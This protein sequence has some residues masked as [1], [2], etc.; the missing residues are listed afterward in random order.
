M[1]YLAAYNTSSFSGSLDGGPIN[2]AI[3]SSIFSGSTGAIRFGD[4]LQPPSGGMTIISDS[5]TQLG[6]ASASATPLFW[7]VN[8]LIDTASIL[9][10]INA[11]PERVT[12][13]SFTTTSSAY[14]YLV[15]SSKY[16]PILGTQPLNTPV[17]DGLVMY[18][19]AGQLV[20]YPTTASTWYDISGNN[21]S[22]SLINGPTFNIN[23]AIV[24]DGVD[25]S[26]TINNVP[27]SY[28]SSSTI[29]V[30]FKVGNYYGTG[31]FALAGYNFTG[32]NYSQGTT[33]IIYVNQSGT[34]F[35]SLI[36]TSQ[37]Y[38]TVTSVSTVPI[39]RYYTATLYK[40]TINGILKLY[41]NGK[42]ESSNTFN[43]ATYAQWP[44]VGTYIG[45]NNFIIG[46]YASNNWGV[47]P[48]LNGS[49]ASTKLY[50]KLLS[51][52]EILQ[53][54]YQAPIVTDGLVFA[55]DANNLVSYESGSSLTYSLT[56]SY[57]GSLT[58]GTRFTSNNGGTFLFDGIDDYINVSTPQSLNPGTGSFSLDFWCNISTN[59]P[60]GSSSCLLEAR[61]TNLYGFLVIGYRND[62]RMQLFI[63]DNVTPN[64]NIY[65][66]TTTP[67]QRGVW[68]HEAMVV[69]RSTQQ[70]T[71]Y[72]NGLQT[73]NK[74]T[75][76][77]TGSI[78]PGSGY[79]YWIGGDLGGAEMNGEIAIS[80]QYN[81]ALTAAEVSQ[82]F[83]AQR[84][85][86][87]I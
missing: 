9:N 78:D 4:V 40:D 52:L 10:T 1:G 33:G 75:I 60:T 47:G 68:V 50:G 56:G 59:V 44:T 85:R 65:Q 28:L 16:F 41:I 66:S 62:G 8:S 70:I 20:S 53:N 21:S 77:D 74:V 49:I 54:Y 12:K 84:S 87:G 80:R 2:I 36:T 14:L 30:T 17:T 27:V 6:V 24:F 82:N 15:S 63:N 81:K 29:D 45:N 22:G 57:S 71:F 42:L 73:G 31:F 76:T 72:Y 3:S 35:G 23:G 51:D 46:S 48:F 61:G 18:L 86:F 11:L 69:D 79:R 37:V 43:T 5:N 67:V 64:Q 19:N 58:N 7:A 26:S 32:G 13:T 39:N 34:V 55:V 38:R 25:D 83:N